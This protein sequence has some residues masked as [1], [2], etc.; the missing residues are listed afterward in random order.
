MI[1]K[2]TKDAFL[3]FEVLRDF[4]YDSEQY[5]SFPLKTGDIIIST[6]TE[7]ENCPDN[8]VRAIGNKQLAAAKRFCNK[9]K[10]QTIGLF[11]RTN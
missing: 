11:G 9:S 7:D 10:H 5:G 8:F 6:A 2:L 4:V 1:L 3:G